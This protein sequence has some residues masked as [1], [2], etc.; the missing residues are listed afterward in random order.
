MTL[1]LRRH[2]W[3]ALILVGLISIT[4]FWQK[5]TNVVQ[6]QSGCGCP[7]GWSI[8][9]DGIQMLD[10]CV[11]CCGRQE[12]DRY[13]SIWH[14]IPR[15]CCERRTADEP[16]PTPTETQAPTPGDPEP[17]SSSTPTPVSLPEENPTPTLKPTIY[18]KSTPTPQPTPFPTN[19]PP[20][21]TATVLWPTLACL[22]NHAARP[23]ALCP[24]TSGW[25]LY[26]I[27]DD[28]EH[29]TGPTIDDEQM[30][31]AVS[32]TTGHPLIIIWD[33]D[34]QAYIF[35]TYYWDGKPYIFT[36]DR[37]DQVVHWEW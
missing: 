33:S 2:S 28:G 27:D 15:S 3:L 12:G 5:W 22:P 6:A 25:N 18:Y 36:L 35:Q 8:T 26:Y 1:M 20:L 16:T 21:D 23:I 37:Q 24:S 4:V 10:V 7:S 19:V 30:F 31:Y 11:I 34:L 32:P 14:P 17:T 13:L 29:Q 9:P